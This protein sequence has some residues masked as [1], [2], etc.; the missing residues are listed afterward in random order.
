MKIAL[1]QLA[2]G[3]DVRAN[4]AAIDR[5]AAEAAGDGAA[6][7]A[8]P[9]YATYE[10][11]KVDATFPAVAEPLD[12]PVCRELGTMARRHRIA[13][14]AGVVETSGDVPRG[15]RAAGRPSLPGARHHGPPPPHRAG[16][17][18]GGDLG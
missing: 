4:L 13:L 17:G 1:G 18:R 5:F 2:S 3:A 6:L 15:G 12:G 7:V 11:K 9:E 10:K 8:F 16:G 14:V